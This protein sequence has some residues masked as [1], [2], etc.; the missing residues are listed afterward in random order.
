M[1]NKYHQHCNAEICLQGPVP[2]HSHGPGTGNSKWL[3]TYIR[4]YVRTSVRT[5]IRSF[6]RS[7]INPFIYS[8]IHSLIHSYI[9][10]HHISYITHVHRNTNVRGPVLRPLRPWWNGIK[11][12]ENLQTEVFAYFNWKIF[13]IYIYIH[14]F[15]KNLE[16]W[17]RTFTNFQCKEHAFPNYPRSACFQENLSKADPWRLA[18]ANLYGHFTRTN[19]ED[20]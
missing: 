2:G 16:D 19:D 18:T 8:F 4:T 17:G 9:H 6:V 15:R 10:T 12:V 5:Y 11:Q 1:T 14:I 20:W 13:T 3:N 7:F